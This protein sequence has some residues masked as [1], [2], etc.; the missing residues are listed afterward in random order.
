M[1]ITAVCLCQRNFRCNRSSG[2]GR[3]RNKRVFTGAE[4]FTGK[5]QKRRCWSQSVITPLL[6]IMRSYCWSMEAY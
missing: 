2:R 4:I 6:E 1:K 5:R 3:A